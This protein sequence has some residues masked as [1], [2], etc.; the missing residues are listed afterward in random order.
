MPDYVKKKGSRY[1][2]CRR[3]PSEYARFDK[4]SHVERGL[5]TSDLATALRRAEIVNR[6]QEIYWE[7]LGDSQSED[8]KKRY[9]AA[10]RT[11]RKMGVEYKTA[12]E[13]RDL[14]L[15]EIVK[16][17][18]LI[19]NREDQDHIVNA[20]TGAEERPKIL[21]SQC[22]ELYYQHVE[23]DL[24]NKTDNQ[25]RKWQ[26]PR[27][28]AF[29]NLIKVIGDKPIQDVT[30]ADAMAFRDSWRGLV[31]N[32]NYKP[33]SAN[34][35]FGHLSKITRELFDNQG[36]AYSEPFRRLR[37]TVDKNHQTFPFSNEWI[38]NKI[39]APNALNGMNDEMRD[40]F[41]MMVNTGMSGSEIVGLQS[42]ELHLSD[43]IPW[44]E[45][46]PN[47]NRALK[48]TFRKRNTP[49]VGVSLE[50]AIRRK[51]KGFPRYRKNPDSYSAAVNKFLSENGLL[52]SSDH[53]AY[54]LRHTFQTNLTHL[55]T[56][57]RIDGELMGHSF[58]RE[59]Y[60]DVSLELKLEFLS[61]MA[62]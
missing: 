9:D 21:L 1:V 56:P 3:V 48:T 58:G 28:K 10:L 51:E 8:A 27:E 36:W 39:L 4:R 26:R 16:R 17:A 53:S 42:D 5:R 34:K 30:R 14:P 23:L 59:K 41:L 45:I 24:S 40:I 50:A 44:V 2:Y 7:S 46:T 13:L 43:P 47:E 20:L 6:E 38:R 18:L 22:C 15:E 37:F 60:G 54:S 32:G 49:L 33:E 35:D 52:E 11:A 31:R 12:D 29:N 19:K 55:K 25:V 62:F 61:K 57:P